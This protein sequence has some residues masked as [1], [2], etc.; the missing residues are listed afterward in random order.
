MTSCGKGFESRSSETSSSGDI[1]SQADMREVIK[2]VLLRVA[3]KTTSRYGVTLFLFCSS[4]WLLTQ[5]FLALHNGCWISNPQILSKIKEKTAAD[6]RM[7]K[8]GAGIHKE[9]VKVLPDPKLVPDAFH[10]LLSGQTGGGPV[11]VDRTVF[12]VIVERGVAAQARAPMSQAKSDTQSMQ[13]K[14]TV[15][16]AEGQREI[17]S[18]SKLVGDQVV[19]EP[20]ANK[21]TIM[22]LGLTSENKTYSHQDKAPAPDRKFVQE[23]GQAMIRNN[24]TAMKQSSREPTAKPYIPLPSGSGVPVLNP[25]PYTLPANISKN[26]FKITK[27]SWETMGCF[28]RV[29]IFAPGANALP[30]DSEWQELYKS[31]RKYLMGYYLLK[32]PESV[33]DII[34]R[35]S[36]LP[37][38]IAGSSAVLVGPGMKNMRK[39]TRLVMDEVK[40][41]TPDNLLKV[42]LF[43]LDNSPMMNHY[44]PSLANFEYHYS[45][46]YHSQSDV[47]IPYGRYR[48]GVGAETARNWAYGKK[49]L[50]AWVED[51][52]DRTFWPRIEYVRGLSKH[53]S[54]D[55]YGKCGNRTCNSTHC[56]EE[57]KGYKFYL[58]LE[59]AAC[60]EFLTLNFWQRALSSGAVPVVYGG[61]KYAYTK[62]APPDSFIHIADFESPAELARYLLKLS[63][64]DLEYNRYHHWRTL[65]SVQVSGPGFSLDSLC[66]MVPQ[67]IHLSPP[68]RRVMSRGKFYR[69]CRKGIY[70]N[71]FA[72]SGDLSNWTPWR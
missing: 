4:M 46:T 34:L 22:H 40:R 33:C 68:K 20:N 55:I 58:A 48:Q 62:V 69:S 10:H 39:K 16:V 36:T 67:L 44:D 14:E 57:L 38:T 24:G 70:V 5:A 56:E 19:A 35:A 27:A 49:G 12:N 51:N 60:D 52:C 23:H 64:S 54:V 25:V 42:Y 17:R 26:V 61:K 32:C 7:S 3:N 47:P 13:Q 71:G 43:S 41:L 45:M 2:V 53:I 65:G 50:V 66:G 31:F 21:N 18:E 11:D 6:C 28:N 8:N 59:E 37:K 1:N 30:K 29:T 72:G 9:Q 63:S 15:D